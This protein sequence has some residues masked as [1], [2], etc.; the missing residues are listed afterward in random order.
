MNDSLFE[1]DPNFHAGWPQ[2]FARH[3]AGAQAFCDAVSGRW[4]DLVETNRRLAA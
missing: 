3:E 2:H 4:L 1:T